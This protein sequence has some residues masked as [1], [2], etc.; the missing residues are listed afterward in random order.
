[1][2]KG[3]PIGAIAKRQWPLASAMQ[4]V[5]LA[6]VDDMVATGIR[7]NFFAFQISGAVVK[8]GNAAFACAIAHAFEFVAAGFGE[9]V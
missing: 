6:Q 3:Q 1:M 9:A 7:R 5:N 2:R 8:N 4:V